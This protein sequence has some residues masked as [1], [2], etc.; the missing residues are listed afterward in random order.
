MLLTDHSL[1]HSTLTPPSPLAAAPAAHHSCAAEIIKRRVADIHQVTEISSL[2]IVD[3]WEPKEE[4]L[5]VVEQQR[6]VSVIQITLSKEPLDTSHIG[7]QPPLPADQV[8]LEGCRLL[9]CR[10]RVVD[11]LEQGPMSADVSAVACRLQASAAVAQ[12]SDALEEGTNGC[13]CLC[14][15]W[16]LGGGSPSLAS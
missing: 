9:L 8:R 5:D 14:C 3:V 13:R 1:S 12:D 7:Y 6:R 2:T 10:L 15:C 4:G 16:V 11:G